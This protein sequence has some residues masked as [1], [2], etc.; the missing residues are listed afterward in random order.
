MRL[1]SPILLPLKAFHNLKE[2]TPF[3]RR[4]KSII[5]QSSPSGIC[6]CFCMHRAAHP[7]GTGSLS[8]TGNAPRFHCDGFPS[9]GHSYS[10]PPFQAC[11][12]SGRLI[13][14]SLA[15]FSSLPEKP[16]HPRAQ[17]HQVDVWQLSVG[18]LG[19]RI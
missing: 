15:L 1:H 16:Q 17:I 6:I 9:S 2:L 8:K 11:E 12:Q 18:A 19:H 4:M 10:K 7:N 14:S 13:D 3:L 5:F